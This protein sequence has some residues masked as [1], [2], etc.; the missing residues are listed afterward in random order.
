MMTNRICFD[1]LFSLIEINIVIIILVNDYVN[2]YFFNITFNC[3][4]TNN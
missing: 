4:L 1:V 3:K 2:R